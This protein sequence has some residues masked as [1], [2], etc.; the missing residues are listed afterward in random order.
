MP[1]LFHA[2]VEDSSKALTKNK[3]DIVHGELQRAFMPVS[4]ALALP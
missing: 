1:D 2:G 4:R 3:L